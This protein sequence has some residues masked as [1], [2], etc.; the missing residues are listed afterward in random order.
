MLLNLLNKSLSVENAEFAFS[1]EINNESDFKS[2]MPYTLRHRD[3]VTCFTNKRIRKV[4]HE[5]RVEIPTSVTQDK[6]S[7][8]KNSNTLW[9]DTMRSNF[10][11]LKVAFYILKDGKIIKVGHNKASGYL[12]FEN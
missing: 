7:N 4:T 8:E 10:D 9:M 2:W 3:R 12:V 1:R 6:M 5:H 11:N